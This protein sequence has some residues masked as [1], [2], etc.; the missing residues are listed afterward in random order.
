[1]SLK[2]QREG[3][4]GHR[5]DA[6]PQSAPLPKLSHTHTVRAWLLI[7]LACWPDLRNSEAISLPVIGER[8]RLCARACPVQQG[9]GTA[10]ARMRASARHTHSF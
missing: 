4:R 6:D 2:L 5:G 7:G 9:Q 10:H 1:M 3:S 8:A